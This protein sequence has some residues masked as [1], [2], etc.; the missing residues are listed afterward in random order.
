MILYRLGP[1]DLCECGL[2]TT[3]SEIDALVHIGLAFLVFHFLP[4]QFAERALGHSLVGSNV[5][6]KMPIECRRHV[7]LSEVRQKS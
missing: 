2:L 6:T 7:C 1:E 4:L 5:Y 3:I